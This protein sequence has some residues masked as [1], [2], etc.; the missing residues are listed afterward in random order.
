M[1]PFKYILF[2]VM[3]KAEFSK[4]VTQIFL[5][6]LKRTAFKIETFCNIMK[7]LTVTFDQFNAALLNK[8]IICLLVLNGCVD[9]LHRVFPQHTDL[10]V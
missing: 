7:A 3:A 1:T 2:P 6:K 10:Y 4:A 9:S 8:S 5:W